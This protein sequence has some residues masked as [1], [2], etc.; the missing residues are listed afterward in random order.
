MRNMEKGKKETNKFYVFLCAVIGGVFWYGFAD[1]IYWGHIN[2]TPTD[3][4][5]DP[6][7]G[8][9]TDGMIFVCFIVASI[10]TYLAY[11]WYRG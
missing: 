6:L 4:F 11:R 2:Y 7:M 3:S 5:I 9:I 1:L 10:F 8:G